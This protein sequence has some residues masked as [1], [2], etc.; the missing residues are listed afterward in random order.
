MTVTP[1]V[2]AEAPDADLLSDVLKAVRLTGSVFLNGRFTAPFAIISPARW[3]GSDAL[4]HLRHASVFHLLARGT[5][6]FENANGERFELRQ[7]DVVLLPFTAEHRFWCGTPEDFVRADGLVRPGPVPG[8]SVVSHGGGGPETRFVCG[9]LESAELMPAPFFRALPEVLIERTYEDPGSAI[10]T[11]SATIIREVAGEPRAGLELMLGRMMELLFLEV[12]RRHAA[13]LPSS[14]SGVLA[15]SRDPL[16]SRALTRI[17]RE[18]GRRWTVEEL[19]AE[20]AS[21]RTVL[22]ERFR[23]VM[24]M[25]PIEYLTS[26]RMQIASDRLRASRAPL[27]RIAEEV[28]YESEASFSRAFRRIMGLSPGAWREGVAAEAVA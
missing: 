28:G 8:V 22:N 18:P 11:L 9:Y 14:A 23:Q 24:G 5:C 7:G 1:S 21:S 25:A 15:A 2:V 6:A 27:A 10:A 12:L 19:A 16:V 26:W 4:S 17:H 3:D 13:R 20:V